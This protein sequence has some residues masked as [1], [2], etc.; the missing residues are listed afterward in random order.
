ME[1]AC[2]LLQEAQEQEQPNT[3]AQPCLPCGG[4][5]SGC[6]EPSSPGRLKEEHPKD[7]GEHAVVFALDHVPQRKCVAGR[8]PCT[9]GLPQNLGTKAGTVAAHSLYVL[10]NLSAKNASSA[11]AMRR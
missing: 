4:V 7:N 9:P 6:A 11:M 5:P 3:S 1:D 8:C 10:P 2:A